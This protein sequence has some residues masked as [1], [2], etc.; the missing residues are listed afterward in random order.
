MDKVSLRKH[1]RALKSALSEGQKLME[2][3]AVFSAIERMPHFVKANAILLYYSLPDELPT[4]KIVS[5]W[6]TSKKV[7]LPRVA[8]DSLEIAPFGQLAKESRY[9]IEEPVSPAVSPS[10][11]DLVIVPAVALDTRGNRLG[12]GK[13]YYDRFLPLC[14][15]A[16]T[17]GVSFD[18]QLVDNLP[19][20]PFDVPLDAVVTASNMII[21]SSS[22]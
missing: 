9:G 13:G 15:S 16:Y 18:C 7:Y 6:A 12:R 21:I 2:A 5:K 22:K 14:Q 19:T 11:I 1:I 17:I 3:D 10:V 4:H 8:G 20:E